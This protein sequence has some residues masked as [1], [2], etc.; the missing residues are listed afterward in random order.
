MLAGHQQE[1]Q[2]ERDRKLEAVRQQRQNRRQRAATDETDHCR[3]ANYPPSESDTDNTCLIES[4][5]QVTGEFA[6]RQQ[7]PKTKPAEKRDKE[8]NCDA[9]RPARSPR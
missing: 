8:R 4:G 9:K 3:F 2:A 7:S 5:D 1:I 6:L